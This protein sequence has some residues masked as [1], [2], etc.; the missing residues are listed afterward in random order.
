[1][2]FYNF[3][4]FFFVFSNKKIEK[5]KYELSVMK[6]CVI[7]LQ[8]W[9]W[10]LWRSEIYFISRCFVIFFS[11]SFWRGGGSIGTGLRNKK[12]FREG[13]KGA[14]N[15]PLQ[16]PQNHVWMSPIILP[17]GVQ[18][19]FFYYSPIEKTQKKYP[20]P[21]IP[22]KLPK[23]YEVEKNF[24]FEKNFL[25]EGKKNFWCDGV[26]Q[27]FFFNGAQMIFKVLSNFFGHCSFSN[28]SFANFLLWKIIV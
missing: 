20:Y 15:P 16:N 5:T 28:F 27:C 10:S 26:W 22:K 3:F 12:I 11:F 18:W 7:F 2:T 25:L 21:V 17:Q 6:N 19:I 24:R 23:S 4:D 8:I 9:C 14:R 1:M 13:A